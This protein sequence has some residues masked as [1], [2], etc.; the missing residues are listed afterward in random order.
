MKNNIIKIQEALSLPNKL[1]IDLRS[2][3]EYSEAHIPG[4]I[5]I[6]L[7]GNEERSLVGTIYKQNSPELAVDQGFEIIAPKL[8][9]ICSQIKKYSKEKTVILYCWRGGMRSKSI[10]NVLSLLETE[11]FL[12][13]GGYKSFRNYVN[14]FFSRPF[15]KELVVLY[16]LT[17]VGKTE[18]LEQ[19]K[20]DNFPVIDLEKLANHRGSVFGSIG[21]GQ[22]PSQK[23]F[24]GLL[25]MECLKYEGV[26]RVAVEC[27]SQRIG[28][29]IIPGTFFKP[30][31]KEKRFFFLI[32]LKT[33]ST[34]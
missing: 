28:Y 4:A 16:G 13:Q 1:F 34:V 33:G 25:L 10:S 30:C 22:A 27:E 14:D 31:K 20:K 8:P 7:L 21:L 3:I 17:G 18:V 15:D 5:N 26:S 12:L 2:P 29:R 32:S 23:Q 11:H 19:L 9:C 24:E 6:P